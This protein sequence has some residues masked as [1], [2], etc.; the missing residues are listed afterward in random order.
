MAVAL[1]S[2][3]STLRWPLALRVSVPIMARV[4]MAC[5]FCL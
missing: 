5:T 1:A 3:D 4:R 2:P